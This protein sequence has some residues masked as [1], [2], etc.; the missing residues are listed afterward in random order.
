MFFP[1]LSPLRS[2]SSK[3]S[4]S[5]PHL[6]VYLFFISSSLVLIDTARSSWS[7]VPQKCIS[8]AENVSIRLWSQTCCCHGG[9]I[10]LSVWSAAWLALRRSSNSWTRTLQPKSIEI[11]DQGEIF[12]SLEG[13]IQDPF[14]PFPTRTFCHSFLWNLK[15]RRFCTFWVCQRGKCWSTQ[16]FWLGWIYLFFVVWMSVDVWVRRSTAWETQ[17]GRMWCYAKKTRFCCK[18]SSFVTCATH[19]TFFS[20]VWTNQ[21]NESMTSNVCCTSISPQTTRYPYHRR[22]GRFRKTTFQNHGKIQ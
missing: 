5:F 14:I 10:W 3:A 13:W 4:H 15:R 6:T 22:P 12:G 8:S 7:L 1:R 11:W 19:A 20:K 17:T 18:H 16:M 9:L 21:E 2:E